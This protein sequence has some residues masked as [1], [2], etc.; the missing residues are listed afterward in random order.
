MGNCKSI[1]SDQG[2]K[3]QTCLVFRSSLHDDLE[4]RTGAGAFEVVVILPDGR[5]SSS[6]LILAQVRSLR[7]PSSYGTLRQLTPHYWVSGPTP[8]GLGRAMVPGDLRLLAKAR[9]Q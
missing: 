7:L 4:G 6:H 1:T 9:L 2:I 5:L 8:F 3:Y